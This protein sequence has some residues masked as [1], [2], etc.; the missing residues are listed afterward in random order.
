MS[1]FD[2]IGREFFDLR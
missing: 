2:G 1:R